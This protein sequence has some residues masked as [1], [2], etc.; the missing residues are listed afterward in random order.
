MHVM[1]H[2]SIIYLSLHAINRL[3]VG[4]TVYHIEKLKNFTERFK[5]GLITIPLKLLSD[6]VKSSFFPP[7][8]ILFDTLSNH[9]CSED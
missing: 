1:I 4:D 7:M 2:A 6:K 3:M 5:S 8:Y 9:A